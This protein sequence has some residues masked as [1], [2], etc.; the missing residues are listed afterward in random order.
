MD[1]DLVWCG[2]VWGRRNHNQNTLHEKYLSSIKKRKRKN[3]SL[4]TVLTLEKFSS[5]RSEINAKISGDQSKYDLW[6]K[7]FPGNSGSLLED[8]VVSSEVATC[9]LPENFVRKARL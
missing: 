2:G 9:Y 8:G 7:C 6:R 3:D 1:V 5:V 4:S